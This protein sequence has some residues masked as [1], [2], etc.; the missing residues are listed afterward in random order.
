MKITSKTLQSDWYQALAQF[1]DSVAARALVQLV[2]LFDSAEGYY[3][4]CENC[5]DFDLIAYFVKAGLVENHDGVFTS[6]WLQR[7]YIRHA[8][9]AK[10]RRNS[11][12][13]ACLLTADELLD[14]GII[15]ARESDD[16]EP[17]GTPL[18]ITNHPDLVK[19]RLRSRRTLHIYRI[20]KRPETPTLQ[21]R[22]SP[23]LSHAQKLATKARSYAAQRRGGRHAQTPRKLS[24]ARAT[25]WGY[26]RSALTRCK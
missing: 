26:T 8:G 4:A 22:P 23:R 15:P 5:A 3:F 21:K 19:I 11:W 24:Y 25:A 14:L 1:G 17:F 12:Q 20:A 9:K 13:T 16:D 10:A 7:E 6:A 18:D 2:I